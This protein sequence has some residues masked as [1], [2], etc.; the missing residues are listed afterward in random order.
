MDSGPIY[1]VSGSSI[2]AGRHDIIDWG[3]NIEIQD[4]EARGEGSL[5]SPLL[6]P[7]VCFQKNQC[8]DS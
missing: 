2:I 6:H 3:W 7:L 8:N 1:P 4:E 5:T